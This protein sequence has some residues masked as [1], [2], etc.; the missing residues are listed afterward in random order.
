[1]QLSKDLS[2]RYFILRHGEST[3]N[4]AGII[5]S[6]PEEGTKEEHTLTAEGENQV[7]K[8]VAQAKSDNVLGE[9]TIIY[10]SPFSRCKRTAEIAKEILG[11]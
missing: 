9:D 11:G 8:S 4:V 10:S 7:R 6:H 3:V 5:L 1:M 2:N